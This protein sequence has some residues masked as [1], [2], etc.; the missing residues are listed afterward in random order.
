MWRSS[1]CRWFEVEDHPNR[2]RTDKRV[3]LTLTTLPSEG[4]LPHTPDV[5]PGR[6]TRVFRTGLNNPPRVDEIQNTF[7]IGRMNHAW[8]A[9]A[10]S[11]AGSLWR[12]AHLAFAAHCHARATTSLSRKP[13]RPAGLG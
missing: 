2:R 7:P 11:S 12:H 6:V 5:L 10:A 3:I 4:K 1:D 8:F 13:G 9:V